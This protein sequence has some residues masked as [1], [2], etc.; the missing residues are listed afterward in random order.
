MFFNKFC[1]VDDIVLMLPGER[2]LTYIEGDGTIL[3][4]SPQPIPLTSGNLVS[5]IQENLGI[6]E[7]PY[8]KE[9]TLKLN[10]GQKLRLAGCQ[11][12]HCI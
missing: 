8:P 10:K 1:G 3:F 4:S 9:D 11:R 5:Y 6:K 2:H 7:T 12:F